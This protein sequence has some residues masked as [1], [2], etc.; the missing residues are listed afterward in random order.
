MRTLIT[1]ALCLVLFFGVSQPQAHSHDFTTNG[2]R[3]FHQ[4][5]SPDDDQA[6]Q[7]LSAA[8]KTVDVKYFQGHVPKD[9][10]STALDEFVATLASQAKSERWRSLA[11]D[12]WVGGKVAPVG[13]LIRYDA[14][15][16]RGHAVQGGALIA[17]DKNAV[18]SIEAGD[19]LP[20][21]RPGL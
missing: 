13:Y 17:V 2:L 20:D 16:V 1:L 10:D 14:V 8:L 18:R 7:D 3:V 4:S 11:V 21:D 19:S 6:Q 15:D 12:I 5:L 9:T